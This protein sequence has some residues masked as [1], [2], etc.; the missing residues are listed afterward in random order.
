MQ[1]YQNRN[2][3]IMSDQ[4]GDYGSNHL[5]SRGENYL[6]FILNQ[7]SEFENFTFKKMLGGVGFFK[8]G[9]M[10]ATIT[11]GKF[12]LVVSNCAPKDC[13]DDISNTSY[14]QLDL[15][16]EKYCAV[17]SEVLNNKSLLSEWVEKAYYTLVK[18][19]N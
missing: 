16:G 5:M 15:Q 9:L 17:P 7:L 4:K 6:N 10:F 8:E 3:Q 1:T 18:S 11:G 14:Y 2:V 13:E 12:R 19:R